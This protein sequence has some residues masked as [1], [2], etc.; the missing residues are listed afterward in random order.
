MMKPTTVI[1][2]GGKAPD[3]L[4]YMPAGRQT[5]HPTVNGEPQ[6]RTLT[7]NKAAAEALNADLARWV[8]MLKAGRVARPCGYFDH[9]KGGGASFTLSEGAAFVWEEGRGV[10]LTGVNW[11]S[12]GREA[13]EGRVYSYFSPRFAA[14]GEQV[15]GL[16]P[17]GVEIGSLVNDPA[18][19]RIERIAASKGDL[20]PARG[21]DGAPAG[22]DNEPAAAKNS[23][24]LT[25]M[26]INE[27]KSL[28]GLPVDAP[29]DALRAALTKCK[30]KPAEPTKKE[31]EAEAA[32]AA[33]KEEKEA[34]EKKCK[35][36]EDELKAARAEIDTLRTNAENG[37]IESAISAGK[38]APK[39]EESIASWRAIFRADSVSASKAM[40]AMPGQKAGDTIT[41]GK[42]GGAPANTKTAAQLYDEEI[43]AL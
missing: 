4:L 2:A 28:L 43:G 26:D 20:A 33:A 5:I 10:V 16:L 31:K 39:D 38:I 23:A 15:T 8:E 14:I 9:E 27:I 30:E 40:A 19:E 34:A 17:D 6:T 11:T 37:F 12:K 35:Q 7:I 41:A 21:I 13:L 24:A 36:T 29:D 3:S 32:L 1:L 18:F 42:N 22:G 25:N